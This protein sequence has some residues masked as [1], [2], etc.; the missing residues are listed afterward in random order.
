MKHVFGNEQPKK[1][2]KLGFDETKAN[3]IRV[4]ICQVDSSDSLY[5]NER[6]RESATHKNVNI[7]LDDVF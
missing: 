6:E 2:F 5:V 4:I 7:K 1:I 3:V